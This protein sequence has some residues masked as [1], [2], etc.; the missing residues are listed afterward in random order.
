MH[1][2]TRIPCN[3]CKNMRVPRS[4]PSLTGPRSLKSVTRSWHFSR[5]VAWHGQVMPNHTPFD[6][7]PFIFIPRP[8]AP[9]WKEIIKNT[10]SGVSSDTSLRFPDNEAQV[11]EG[12]PT[13]QRSMGVTAE[14]QSRLE[15]MPVIYNVTCNLKAL[16]QLFYAFLTISCE[17]QEAVIIIFIL[18]I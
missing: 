16:C 15:T 11:Q 2:C 9:A 13:C 10:Q 4:N 8:K 18:L 3:V 5:T 6:N 14:A 7:E 12:K 17:F 1:S